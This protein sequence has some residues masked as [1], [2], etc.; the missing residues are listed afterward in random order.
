MKAFIRTSL[1]ATALVT[2][3]NFNGYTQEPKGLK[4]YYKDYFPIGVAVNSR[5]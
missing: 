5:S 4:E 1:Y 3:F 2:L